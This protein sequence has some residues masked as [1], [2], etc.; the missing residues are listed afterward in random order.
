MVALVVT[1]NITKQVEAAMDAR[2]PG[3]EGPGKGSPAA[4]DST[5]GARKLVRRLVWFVPVGAVVYVVL[6]AAGDVRESL[7]VLTGVN[8]WVVV[9]A[10]L[11]EVAT[12]LTLARVYRASLRAVGDEMDYWQALETSMTAFTVTQVLPGGGAVAV[13]VATRRMIHFG[14]RRAGAAAAAVL[15]GTLAMLTLGLLVSLALIFAVVTSS[16]PPT[17][18]VAT[19]LVVVMLA[20]IATVVLRAISS[21][22]FGQRLVS[23]AKRWLSRLD[24]DFDSWGESLAQ[25][26]VNRPSAR[27]LG[28]VMGW[29]AIKWSTDVAALWLLLAGLGEPLSVGVLFL[30]FGVAHFA[31]MI[32][33]SPGG[34][35]L[36][37]A[38]MSGTLVAAGV[39][40]SVAVP[41]VLGYRLLSY[42]LPLLA[43]IPQYLRGPALDAQADTGDG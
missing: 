9:A 38:G 5:N 34:L 24:V 16:L 28:A 13:V 15:S 26:A 14:A 27:R 23:L 20:G 31:V 2:E 1:G 4:A 36:A 11:A 12:V 18:L 35:G 10:V 3:P 43:G 25:V 30:T 17:V 32:P 7:D 33:I 22:A 39:P 42:W 37:E 21:V 29:A 19:L 41:G 40:A 8:A 6:L